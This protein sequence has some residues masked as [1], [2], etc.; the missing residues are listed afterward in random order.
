MDPTYMNYVRK[1]IGREIMFGELDAYGKITK[2]LPK[3]E[4]PT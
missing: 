2:F 4:A 1:L 3:V